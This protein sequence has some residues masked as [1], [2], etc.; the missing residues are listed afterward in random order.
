MTHQVK[1]KLDDS[2]PGHV[3]SRVTYSIINH[4]PVYLH[5][6]GTYLEQDVLFA[7]VVEIVNTVIS[8][9]PIKTRYNGEFVDVVVGR[10]V[11]VQQKREKVDIKLSTAD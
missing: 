4:D 6:H 5:D 9:T 7:G 10:I 1:R 2:E 11:K 3:V 8:V